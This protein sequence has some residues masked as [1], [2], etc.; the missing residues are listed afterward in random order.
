MCYT[1]LFWG[2]SVG[3]SKVLTV[4]KLQDRDF[5]QL[6]TAALLSFESINKHVYRCVTLKVGQLFTEALK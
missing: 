3:K 1:G 4:L 5:L 2:Q 6:V